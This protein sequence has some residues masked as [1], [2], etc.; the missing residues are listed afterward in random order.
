MNIHNV[1]FHWDLPMN[2]CNLYRKTRNAYG[3]PQTRTS[4]ARGGYM[5]K[6]IK[7]KANNTTGLSHMKPTIEK[8]V[9]DCN[10]TYILLNAASNCTYV[11]VMLLE[12]HAH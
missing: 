7:D 4:S 9:K 6:D 12:K 5:R 8:E 10:C 11:L 3:H 2:V 1:A